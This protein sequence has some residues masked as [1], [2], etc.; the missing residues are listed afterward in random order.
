MVRAGCRDRAEAN[1]GRRE[2]SLVRMDIEMSMGWLFWTVA[3]LMGAYVG[4][5]VVCNVMEAVIR[6]WKT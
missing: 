3:A 6:N 4:Y 2:T 1:T 5:I